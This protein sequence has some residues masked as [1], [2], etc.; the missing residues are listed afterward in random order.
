MQLVGP[1]PR[2]CKPMCM[3]CS[4]T[5]YALKVM[6]IKAYSCHLQ[7]MQ[8]SLS[9]KK[10]TERKLACGISKVSQQNLTRI[11]YGA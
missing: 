7:C 6:A 3:V 11:H 1:V 9:F 10:T 5:T 2:L 8:S 4:L